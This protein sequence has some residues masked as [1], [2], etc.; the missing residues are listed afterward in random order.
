MRYTVSAVLLLAACVG[1]SNT[2][3][4]G[5]AGEQIKTN[6]Y[7]EEPPEL[8]VDVG[9]IGLS[10][11]P[12]PPANNIELT[13]AKMAGIVTVKPDGKNFWQVSL[14]DKGRALPEAKKLE[15]DPP[16]TKGGCSSQQLTIPLAT[17]EFVD[18]TGITG[19][20]NEAQVDFRYKWKPTELGSALNENGAIYTKLTADQQSSIRN[21]IHGRST[22]FWAAAPLE[23]PITEMDQ[24]FGVASKA[25]FQKYDDGWRLI[26]P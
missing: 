16:D 19:S 26:T 25:R 18:V 11:E 5:F 10:C 20:E 1:C 14:T 4:R 7:L 12:L 13:I 21:M 17:R 8:W 9:R 22:L 15:S 2:L 24:N 3:N 6:T 23:L